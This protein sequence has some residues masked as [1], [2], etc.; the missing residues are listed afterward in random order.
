MNLP[1]FIAGRYLFA[2]KSHNVINIISAISMAGMAVGTAAL[3]IILSVYNG[4]NDLVEKSL[5][6]ADP[7]IAVHPVHGKVFVPEGEAFD[8]LY[9]QECVATVSEVL[10]DNVFINYDDK[11]AIAVAKGVDR[12]FE[13]ESPVRN[14]VLDGAFSLHKGSLPTA[15]VSAGLARKLD[16]SPRFLS[17]MDIYYPS[18][19]GTFSPSDPVSSLKSVSMRP[20]SVFSINAEVDGDMLIMPIEAMRELLQYE[21]EVSCVEIR[22]AEG[23]GRKD[24]SYIMDGLSERLGT[25]FRVLDR[26]RQNASVFRMMK[27]EKGAIFLILIFIIIIISFSIFG[28]LSMLMIEK[29][30][31]MVTLRCLGADGRLIRRIFV[32]EGWFI[33]LVGLAAGLVIGTVFSLA[34]QKFG[35]IRMPHGFMTDSYPVIL[36]AGDIA[37]TAAGTALIGYII[38]LMPAYGLK[39]SRT[40]E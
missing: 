30:D 2:R 8:W 1:L 28:C 18:R 40:D 33:S 10:S 29:Q 12:V 23:S 20:S 25:E 37:A 26:R 17:R 21:S 11:Q 15:S 31:D 5:G 27:Y 14:Y 7:D 34:Q 39:K 19:T 35:F 4:F 9:G 13:E 6:E 22:L 38:A 3:I 24:L 16:L 32:L 36:K